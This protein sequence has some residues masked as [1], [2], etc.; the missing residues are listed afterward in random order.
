MQAIAGYRI[1]D[2]LYTS[3]S[4]LVYRALGRAPGHAHAADDERPVIIKTLRDAHP[5]PERIAWFRREYE[6]TRGLSGLAGIIGVHELGV[7]Q[8]RWFMV[9]DD[10]GASSLAQLARHRRFSIDEIVE[11]AIDVAD[12]L[13][14]IHERHVIHKDV[15][16]ANIV[17]APDTRTLAIIDFGISTTLSRESPA[18]RAPSELEGTLAYMSPEQTGRMNRALDYRTDFYSLGVT[19]Y[20]LASGRLPFAPADPLE[21]IHSHIARQPPPLHQVEPGVDR[22]FSDIVARLLAKNAEDR[23]QS[24]HGLAQD[25]RE[26]RRQRR[27][28]AVAPF[29]LAR[30]DVLDRFEIPQKLYGRKHEKERL[31]AVFERIAEGASELMLVSGYS[32]IGKSALVKELYEPITR[33]RGYFIAGKFDQLQRDIPYGPIIQAFRGLMHQLLS[34]SEERVARWRA[35]LLAALGAS[36]QVIID[37]IPELELVIGAQPAVPELPAS[38]AQNRFKLAFQRFIA[39]FTRPEHPLALFIDDLQWVD[40]ASLDLIH[41]LLTG[42][43]NHHLFVIGAYR[44]N[45]VSE[46][47][48]L[49]PSLAALRDAGV[50]LHEIRL[51]P[52]D[53]EHV[54]QL[55]ADTLRCEPGAARPL[56]ELAHAR[57]GGNPFFLAELLK[58]LHA[59]ALIRFDRG[60]D[61]GRWAWR[62][63]IDEIR[64][65]GMPDNAVAFM[66]EKVRKL[67]RATQQALELAACTG[68]VF[69]LRT[70]AIVSEKD[71]GQVAADL[72]DAVAEGLILPLDDTYRLADLDVQGLLASLTV[73]YRFAHDRI[74]QAAYS[75]I[76]GDERRR[77]HWKVGKLLLEKTPPAAIDQHVFDIVNQLN[78]GLEHARDQAERDELARLD[79]LAGRKAKASAAYEP[80]LH[81]LRAGIALL[82]GRGADFDPGA[83]LALT[84]A[85][86]GEAVQRRYRLGLEL[87]E[88]AAEAACL[89]GSYEEMHRLIAI[90]RA[91]AA[92][93]LDA[94]GSY[95]VEIQ[96]YAA[97][98][99]LREGVN[100]GLAVLALL[101]IEIPEE[102]DMDAI[103]RSA[104]AAAAAWAGRDIEG[105]LDAPGMADPQKLAAMEIMA[106]LYIPAFNSAPGV[107]MLIVFNEVILSIAH[108]NA[109]SSA[110][111]FMAYGFL[112]CTQGDVE[113]GYAFGRVALRLADRFGGQDKGS[114]LFM[115]D[116]FVRHWRESLIEPPQFLEGY[117]L[118]LDAG[119]LEYA[120]LNLVGL[121]M[122]AFW[123]GEELSRVAELGARH[124]ATIRRFKQE[125]PLE[126][127]DVY[128]QTARN[129]MGKS[130]SPCV[131]VSEAYDERAKLA[132]YVATRNVTEIALLHVSKLVLCCVFGD[133]ERAVENARVAE[134][135]L[136]GITASMAMAAFPFYDALAFL[137]CW[138]ALSD[139]DRQE[140]LARSEKDLETL[141]AWSA[142]APQNFE[143]RVS[144]VAA[145]RARVLGQA[146]EAR[147]L[148]DRAIGLAQQHG[149][150]HEEAL[151]HEHAARFHRQ[152]G[153]GRHAHLARNYLHDARYAYRRWGATAKVAQLDAAFPQEL[154]PGAH[155]PAELR[156]GAS[157][158]STSEMRAGETL[159]LVS[160]L[161]A[162]QALS[163]EIVL[164][165][166]LRKLLA[167]VIENAGAQR[168]CLVLEQ[169]GALVVE[170]EGAVDDAEARLL[171]SIPLDA[172][173]RLLTGIVYLVARTKKPEVLDDAS[174]SERFAADA[175]VQRTR[176]KSILCMPLVNQGKLTAILYLE[177]NLVTA[178]FTHERIEVLN[179]LSA[180]M[181]IAIDNA[182]L[183]R[184]LEAANRELAAYSHTLENMVAARTSELAAKNQELEATL[185]QLRNTQQQLITREK[186]ASLGMLTAGIAHELR[187]PLNFINNFAKLSVRQAEELGNRLNAWAEK[188]DRASGDAGS[189][190]G[191]GGAGS[192]PGAGAADNSINELRQPLRLLASNA[193]LIEKHGARANGIISSMLLHAQ[194]SSEQPVPTDLNGLLGKS[195]QLVYHGMRS[196]TV[197][198]DVQIEESYDD[199]IGQVV[200]VP[201]DLSRVFI[202]IIENAGYATQEQ[203]RRRGDGFVPR[204]W[205][206]TVSKGAQL[207][208]RIRDN[209]TGIAR[210]H[211]DK[212]FMPFF[213]T[214]P[215]GD[216]TGLGLSLSYDVVVHKHRG[217]LR[218]DSREG[219]Y[220]EFIIVLP[221]APAPPA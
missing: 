213:T 106:R 179:L 195:V 5:S 99:Q 199:S 104:A 188:M 84:P 42:A 135:N 41:A 184:A 37:V 43:E 51:Q 151:A 147:E 81:Y 130:E 27:Q 46:S 120:S 34:E 211:L 187:N 172:C 146:A 19:L 39:V 57:T 14:R 159:D 220:T 21:L 166:L 107:F 30:E 191:A 141:R 11:V 163:G 149:Y 93:L 158:T 170:A 116:C 95:E 96:A 113:S 108:G 73:T 173:D 202:N 162:S 94:L 22:V 47:H 207:E 70:L 12:A 28:G 61:R 98:D 97:R 110:R 114:A 25:L 171:E 29:P 160:I 24:A 72:R 118:A 134:Q 7:Q 83:A 36:G 67:G 32:G 150:V 137:G 119:D 174:T 79:L 9:L 20:E 122:H 49:M 78:Q 169:D 185:Q 125:L 175:Y 131:M 186:L 69:D 177:N 209:G 216:G 196:R 205:V 181:A 212:I 59:G 138:D 139:A 89:T 111:G 74:Q 82:L 121:V 63:D 117:R 193:A 176:P 8:H 102:P 214:K 112:L 203:A 182:R 45:E 153:P 101:G 201:Q 208:I 144:L 155:A 123:S 58:Y 33:R 197:P 50:V 218:V 92:S 127:N 217:E 167:T 128:W 103:G 152:G 2:T 190:P 60:L 13:G 164:E 132:F 31:L 204:I 219:E 142:H 88:E 221:M 91:H 126:T 35:Q 133:F 129:L 206:T 192:A 16:P 136:A 1:V 124:S 156:A 54:C 6:T 4:S 86:V 26:Y 3:A 68:N 178:A 140:A 215:A 62:W 76:A 168:A 65:C 66:A 161:K 109:S 148:Y 198:V 77:V 56:A 23:Y 115:F 44:D 87:F 100:A 40:G 75:L 200:V 55:I 48:P 157:A 105:L 85:E 10:I 183:Y 53:V 18:V 64:A 52:L 143:H 71:P 145:E 194:P 38:E 80:A 154:A 210:E 17:L 165:G 15:N 90:V 180:E 189:A